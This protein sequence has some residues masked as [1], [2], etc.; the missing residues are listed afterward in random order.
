MENKEISDYEYV[1]NN[2]MKLS[3]WK[4]FTIFI[5]VLIILL[6]VFMVGCWWF[7]INDFTLGW[8]LPLIFISL[9]IGTIYFWYK[10]IEKIILKSKILHYSNLYD[11][12]DLSESEKIEF[13][14]KL[15]SE[16]ELKEQKEEER[17][18]EQKEEETYG[19]ILWTI[20]KDYIKDENN[21]KND[22]DS[23]IINYEDK[24]LNTTFTQNKFLKIIFIILLVILILFG[25]FLAWCGWFFTIELLSPWGDWYWNFISILSLLFWLLFIFL[26]YKKIKKISNNKICLCSLF[27]KNKNSPNQK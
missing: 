10:W 7:F 26:W 15:E 6:G 11:I 16:I 5:L 12:K 20:W 2:Q 13:I 22:F 27:K 9:W 24:K 23:K 17:K 8:P 18:Q 14:E 4:K 3:F 21:S 19:N 25:M 1:K